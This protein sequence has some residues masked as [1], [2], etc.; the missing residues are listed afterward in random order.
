MNLHEIESELKEINSYLQEQYDSR[1]D[2]IQERI[3][4]ICAY[5][6]RSSELKANAKFLV[7]TIS[8]EKAELLNR[9]FPKIAPTK[10]QEILKKH[11]AR[12]NM[13][14]VLSDR[15]NSACSHQ[16]EA[17]RSILSYIKAEI[18]NN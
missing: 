5:L 9:E 4:K 15:V 7:D 2:I 11:T 13:I 14:L 8:G 18:F 17:L 16:S 12:E 6:S 10:F 3:K 1:P